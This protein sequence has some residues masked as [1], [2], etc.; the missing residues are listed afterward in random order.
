MYFNY[1]SRVSYFVILEEVQEPN[2]IDDRISKS[3]T[4]FDD[5]VITRLG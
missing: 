3:K 1:V 2:K 4:T 5:T